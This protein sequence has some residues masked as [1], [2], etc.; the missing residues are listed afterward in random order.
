MTRGAL[1]PNLQVVLAYA[2]H[3]CSQHSFG[4]PLRMNADAQKAIWPR[5]FGPSFS[6]NPITRVFTICHVI[7]TQSPAIERKRFDFWSLS[8][9]VRNFW[10]LLV[11]ILIPLDSDLCDGY[12]YPTFEQL[13]PGGHF[14]YFHAQSV[15]WGKFA[16][17]LYVYFGAKLSEY[18]SFH[19]C[20]NK[21]M[22]SLGE[23]GDNTVFLMFFLIIGLFLNLLTGFW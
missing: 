14:L 8:P 18:L 7:F 11:V 2:S 16:S 17:G 3:V 6:R 22:T 12:H 9:A 5:A 19:G 1:N 13:G 23:R 21:S 15:W 10:L 20:Y 4:L